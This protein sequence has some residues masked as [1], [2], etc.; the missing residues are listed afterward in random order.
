MK[1]VH[2]LTRFLRAGSEENTVATCLWQVSAGH[3]VTIVH[4]EGY[5]PDW[6]EELPKS[7]KF[8]RVRHLVHPISPA[9]DL[10]AYMELKRLFRDIVPDVV[11]T[12]QSKA[13][14]VARAAARHLDG[15]TAIHGLHIVNFVGVSAVKRAVYVGLERLAARWTDA[16]IAVSSS[17][18]EA[19][20]NVGVAPKDQINVV[21]SGMDVDRFRE[22]TRPEDADALTGGDADGA[23]P[24]VLLMIAAFEKRKRHL[25]FMEALAERRDALPR[26]KMLFAGDGPQRKACE[27]RSKALGLTDTVVFCGYRR[28][29][30][31]LI[32]MSDVCVLASEREGLPRV[33]IQ[34]LAAG[35]PIVTANLGSLDEV[36]VDQTNAIVAGSDPASVVDEIV[37]LLRNPPKMHALAQSAAATDLSAWSL[38]ALGRRSTELYLRTRAAKARPSDR[39]YEVHESKR[40]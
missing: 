1:I 31:R 10:L 32:A 24:K 36:I 7:I 40:L 28:D 17:V 26:V 38:D 5:D 14:I 18:A 15:M 13:G 3:D 37:E 16:F 34:Y 39:V 30:E 8:V 33:L 9:S 35:K 21:Y 11:H 4:G 12:H 23:P 27:E 25:E 19:Y 22:A 29:P 20:A 6:Y 2:V